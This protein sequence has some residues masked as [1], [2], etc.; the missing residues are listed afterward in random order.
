MKRMLT[1]LAVTAT[2]GT[3]ALSPATAG[4][5]K[6]GKGMMGGGMMMGHDSTTMMGMGCNGMMGMGMMMPRQIVAVDEGIVVLMGNKLIKYDKDLK[7]VKEISLEL[8]EEAM[9]SMME[10]MNMMHSKYKSM[11]QKQ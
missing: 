7:K 2:I 11:M 6:H 10:Q 5:R 9:N 4:P 8:D 1:L 3:F